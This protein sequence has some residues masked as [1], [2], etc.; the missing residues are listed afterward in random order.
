MTTYNSRQL[1][2]LT[3]Q[4]DIMKIPLFLYYLYSFIIFTN[5]LSDHLESATITDQSPA[6]LR[7]E[8]NA[9]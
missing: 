5:L 3:R 4:M 8:Q 1:M 9:E 2:S 6:H 7:A